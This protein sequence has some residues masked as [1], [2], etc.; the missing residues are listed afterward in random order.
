M[1][2]RKSFRKACINTILFDFIDQF[3]C[4]DEFD[5]HKPTAEQL[6]DIADR[7]YDGC[8]NYA[9]DEGWWTTKDCE[10]YY[11]WYESSSR[12]AIVSRVRRVFSSYRGV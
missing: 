5:G 11:K 7:A 1:T 6:W 3:V 12:D 8:D 2:N 10:E 9:D 4:G